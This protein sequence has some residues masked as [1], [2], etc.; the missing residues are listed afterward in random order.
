[1][2]EKTKQNRPTFDQK[3]HYKRWN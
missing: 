1:M 3:T 2:A